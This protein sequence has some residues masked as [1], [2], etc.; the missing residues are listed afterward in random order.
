MNCFLIAT[1]D[2]SIVPPVKLFNTMHD[3]YDINA[4]ENHIIDVST[5]TNLVELK[6]V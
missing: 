6:I 3:G 5:F 4:F 2:L 1:V